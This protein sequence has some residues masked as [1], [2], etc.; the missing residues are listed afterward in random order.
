MAIK[1]LTKPEVHTNGTGAV[2]PKAVA[3][4]AFQQRYFRKLIANFE[5]AQ[6]AIRHAQDAA[7][8]FV[9]SCAENEG[10]TLG[11]DGWAFDQAGLEFIRVPMPPATEDGQ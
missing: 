9:A 1:D 5:R 7:N 8:E 6:E 2:E 11:Q 10:I 3:M 4:S